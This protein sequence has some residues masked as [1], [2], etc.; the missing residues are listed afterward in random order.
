MTI[1]RLRLSCVLAIVFIRLLLFW[2]VQVA[3]MTIPPPWTPSTVKLHGVSHAYP[4]SFWRK[5][6]SS[7]PRRKF[8]LED[9]TWTFDSNHLH[10]LTGVSSSGKSTILRLIASTEDPVAGRLCVSTIANDDDTESYRS[11]DQHA[12][13]VILDT[14]PS[15]RESDSIADIWRGRQRVRSQD[16]DDIYH[17]FLSTLLQLPLQS[18]V[19]ELSTSQ[20]YMCRLGEAC[21]DSSIVV[22]VRNVLAD[23]EP[24]MSMLPA[25]ILLLDEWLDAETT[26][27]VQSI[28]KALQTLMG[29]GAVVICVTHKPERFDTR[30]LCRIALSQGKVISTTVYD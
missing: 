17:E 10:L 3:S 4:D 24:T 25:P 19:S 7:V 13:P 9:V 28:Q 21:L 5:M 30:N 2:M 27:V 29:A 16:D 26:T 11:D 20:V 15:Y 22:D 8:S 12:R 14:R 18:K 23:E 6:T 1:R